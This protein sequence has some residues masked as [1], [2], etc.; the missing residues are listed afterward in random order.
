MAE[1]SPES[2]AAAK[3]VDDVQKDFFYIK[4][5]KKLYLLGT[6]ILH[7][8]NRLDSSKLLASILLISLHLS[9]SN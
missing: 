8:E 3:V 6:Y 4:R 2:R 7:N 9:K 1:P 5:Q